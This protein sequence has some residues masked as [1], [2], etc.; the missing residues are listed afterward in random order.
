MDSA[1]SSSDE[2][3]I[4][5]LS[6]IWATI[7]ASSDLFVVW[8]SDRCDVLNVEIED[9]AVFVGCVNVCFVVSCVENDDDM[10]LMTVSNVG[11]KEEV[12]IAE[13]NRKLILLQNSYTPNVSHNTIH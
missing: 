12:D 13:P 11:E 3:W 7:D 2:T 5:S 10:L 9:A 6:T 4:C 1:V 8:E